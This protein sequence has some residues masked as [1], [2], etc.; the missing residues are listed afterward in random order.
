MK[1][2]ANVKQFSIILLSLLLVNPVMAQ[3]KNTV[4]QPE[5]NS[6]PAETKEDSSEQKGYADETKEMQA[7]PSIP[8]IQPSVPL[9]R[10]A[11]APLRPEKPKPAGFD[12]AA[13][14]YKSGMTK[15]AMLRFEKFL[16]D[17][18]ADDESRQ[19]LAACYQAQKMYAKALAQ[20]DWLK[21]N[22]R[23]ITMQKSAG[24]SAHTIRCYQNGICPANCLKLS[25]PGWSYTTIDG[26]K[27]PMRW[28]KFHESRGTI[29]YSEHHLGELIEFDK[30]GRAV[31]RGK[32][33]I[34]H[35]TGHVPKL[36]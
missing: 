9:Q 13:K 26:K 27:S 19:Y 21:A 20:Y 17:G 25:M 29:A 22:A 23:S 24:A 4:L 35:G 32:C 33:P 16:K 8:E 30:E 2:V 36:K 28:I 14:M 12:E 6:E 31:S 34:C 10:P 5:Q 15:D 7:P 11:P 1:L 3:E 18:T